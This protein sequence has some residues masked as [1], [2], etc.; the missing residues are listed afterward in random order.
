MRDYDATELAYKNGYEA[1]K[2]DIE[3]ACKSIYLAWA[4]KNSICIICWV[5][6][7]I[8][9]NKWWIALFAILFLS[10]IQWK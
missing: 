10:S 5:I 7:A 6:L 9:F 3:N 4:I 1:G 8:V 2:K